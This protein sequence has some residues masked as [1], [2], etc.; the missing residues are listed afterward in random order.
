M[1]EKLEN[2]SDKFKLIV[3]YLLR[4]GVGPISQSIL[5][6]MKGLKVSHVIKSSTLLSPSAPFFYRLKV[7]YDGII[8]EVG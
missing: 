2:M 4:T 1:P 5:I 7:A 3:L 6:Q 8:W